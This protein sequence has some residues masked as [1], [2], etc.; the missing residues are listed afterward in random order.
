MLQNLTAVVANYRSAGIR[1]FP[2]AL[3]VESDRE[4][5][6]IRGALAMPM[7]VVRLSVGLETIKER[8]SV[9]VTADREV[10]LHWAELWLDQGTGVG[11]EDFTVANDRPIREVAL[12]VMK[13]IGWE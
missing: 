13:G 5:A 1:S 2:P 9:A 10:D 7:R 6:G 11:L 4:V 12:D 3:S 8:L